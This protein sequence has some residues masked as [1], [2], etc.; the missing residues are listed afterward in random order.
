MTAPSALGARESRT[1]AAATKFALLRALFPAFKHEDEC[2][3]RQSLRDACLQ[4][5]LS[6]LPSWARSQAWKL[7]LEYLP[8]EKS[9]WTTTVTKRRNEYVRFLQDFTQDAPESMDRTV[10]QIYCDLMRSAEKHSDFLLL[11]SEIHALNVNNRHAL[12][13]RLEQIHLPY[14]QASDKYTL[15]QD[16]PVS[17]VVITYR[18]RHWHSLLRIL[19]V[20]AML[21]P[22]VGYIQGMHE[23]LLVLLRVFFEARNVSTKS[24][25]PWEAKVLGLVD[26]HDMEA[27]TFWCFS[28]LMGKFREVFDF[29]QAD[30]SSLDEMRQLLSPGE[31]S[32]VPN[33]GM[34]HALRRLSAQLHTKDAELWTFLHTHELDPQLPYYAFRWLACLLAADMPPDAVAELW[35]VLFSETDA[36]NAQNAHID[37]LVSMCCAML[38]LVRDTLMPLGA[39]EDVFHAGMHVLQ[40]Y[41]IHTARPI[42]S[43]AY[44]MQQQPLAFPLS[45]QTVRPRI[46]SDTHARP[47]LQDRLAAS[48][49]RGLHAP[50][51]RSVSWDV[52]K[53]RQQSVSPSAETHSV[54]AELPSLRDARGILR[55]YTDAIQDSNAAASVSKAS[56]N[57]A[58]K[59]L[60]W[61]ISAPAVPETSTPTADIEQLQ[62]PPRPGPPELPMPTVVDSPTDRDTFHRTVGTF[63]AALV[64]KPPT[65][66]SSGFS[67]SSD[68]DLSTSFSLPSL[69]AAA[70]LGDPASLPLTPSQTQALLTT[71]SPL[72]AQIRRSGGIRSRSGSSHSRHTSTSSSRSKSSPDLE[73]QPSTASKPNALRRL[74]LLPQHAQPPAF[75]DTTS[76]S[77]RPSSH[78]SSLGCP[79]SENLETLLEEMQMDEW[80]R[81]M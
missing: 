51:G 80:I 65:C 73:S 12:L 2:V 76:S 22:S 68:D 71:E 55:R 57:I 38:L 15:H 66:M 17:P 62:T 9:L 24:I 10:T 74:P 16:P 41:P 13:Q 64:A 61:S 56:T 35:D 31:S 75:T 11:Q 53:A 1:G 30:V 42:I 69:Q 72:S 37:M 43:L 45:S 20:Y 19:Y 3:P 4:G 49:Q 8:A 26:T 50:P 52:T 79:P 58:A 6:R 78:V 59:A 14:R 81:P 33:N 40:S 63:D 7:L 23:I 5:D 46:R 39:Q 77:S 34:A 60:A 47:T 44:Q 18:D 27:D 54:S 32:R 67:P 36:R 70:Q 28:L 48:V 29:G 21:N 25:Q